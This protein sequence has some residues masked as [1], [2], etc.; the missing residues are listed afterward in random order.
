VV[1]VVRAL[2]G[3]KSSGAAWR[4]MFNTTVLGMGFVPTIADP[5][6]YRKPRAKENGFKYYEYLLVYVDDVLILSHNPKVHLEAIQAQYELNPASIGPPSRYLGADVWK[7]TRPGDPTGREYW[8]FSA[9]TYVKN[10]VRNV[11]LLLK[12]EGRNLK[13]TAKSPFSSTT[14]RPELDTTDECDKEQA[15]RY[16]QLIG[17][18]RWAVE[19]GRIDMYTE[20]SL[21]SASRRDLGGSIPCICIFEQA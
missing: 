19:L 21:L 8:A 10:A 4:E 13:T 5:D 2:Y 11:K 15:S 20:V 6:V 14:Y 7:V 3:L 16:S 17:V 12:E 9:N 1:K 18:L